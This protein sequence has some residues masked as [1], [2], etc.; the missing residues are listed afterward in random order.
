[1]DETAEAR[2]H[3]EQSEL[4]RHRCEINWLLRKLTAAKNPK[5]AADSYIELV[6]KH[7]GDEAAEKLIRDTRK[8][9]ATGDRGQG[10]IER[11]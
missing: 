10:R 11:P 4:Y 2:K 1:M 3:A 7:R 5:T 9:W 8:A 6:R